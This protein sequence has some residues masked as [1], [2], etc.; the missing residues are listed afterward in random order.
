MRNFDWKKATAVF[1]AALALFC[2]AILVLVVFVI[3]F[4][5]VHPLAGAAFLL[6][7]VAT[8]FGV[9]AGLNL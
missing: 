1:F 3:I 8:V 4:V 2:V 9:A 7:F 5:H 6:L